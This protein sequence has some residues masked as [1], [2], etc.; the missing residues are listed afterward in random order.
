MCCSS[1]S[2]CLFPRPG[3]ERSPGCSRTQPG[4]PGQRG[5]VGRSGDSP[6]GAREDI[7]S[8]K[9][10]W[11]GNAASS[12]RCQGKVKKRNHREQAGN[13]GFISPGAQHSWL[14][15]LLYQQPAFGQR[16]DLLQG[17]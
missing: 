13:K 11:R 16:L 4:S 14:Q 5:E 9:Q 7:A 15:N 6:R 10:S 8:E 2:C 17:F 1:L 3:S 12:P